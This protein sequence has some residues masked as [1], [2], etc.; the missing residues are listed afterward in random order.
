MAR[1]LPWLN[2]G[3]NSTHQPARPR[4]PKRQRTLDP[5]SD[6]DDNANTHAVVHPKKQAAPTA[7]KPSNVL[8][9]YIN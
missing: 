1:T 5:N 7:G 3:A 9:S 6:S 4:P 8:H 2:S